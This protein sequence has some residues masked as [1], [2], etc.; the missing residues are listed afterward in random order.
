[1]S[2]CSK[3]FSQKHHLIKHQQI[4]TGERPFVCTNCS[5]SFS[6]KCHLLTHQ[7]IHTGERP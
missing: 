3:S 4:H 6:R 5:K 1:C 7:R 2:D